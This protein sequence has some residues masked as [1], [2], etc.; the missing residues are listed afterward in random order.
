M[1]DKTNAQ[2]RVEIYKKIANPDYLIEGSVIDRHKSYIKRKL[3]NVLKGC[4][5][6]LSYIDERLNKEDDEFYTDTIDYMMNHMAGIMKF[7][8]D[9]GMDD[10]YVFTKETDRQEF[11]NNLHK[12]AKTAASVFKNKT[13]TDMSAA[14]SM[15]IVDQIF[16]II[17][18][19]RVQK[20]SMRFMVKGENIASNI[21]SFYKRVHKKDF[22]HLFDDDLKDFLLEI[23]SC[24]HNGHVQGFVPFR[25]QVCKNTFKFESED[26][27]LLP[28]IS[29]NFTGMD[30]QG[31]VYGMG[32]FYLV[33]GKED[34]FADVRKSV[35]CGTCNDG[36]F[37]S[38]KLSQ[39]FS[40]TQLKGDSIA[41]CKIPKD[42]HCTFHAISPYK[43]LYLCIYA[44]DCYYHRN[45]LIRSNSRL[46]REY[47]KTPVYMITEEKEKRGKTEVT[48]T[49]TIS[50]SDRYLY[51]RENN[52]WKG[53]H[54]AS[55][56][57]HER[58]GFERRIFDKETGKV[59][60]VVPVKATHVK[61]VDKEVIYKV[62]L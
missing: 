59:K 4:G 38:M 31:E 33:K 55:P 32:E 23:Q 8:G 10:E 35:I 48:T 7:I 26:G 40:G 25:V 43:L 34:L 41:L 27:T 42:T 6:S 37:C 56:V 15:K 49:R 11:L 20:Q 58:R 52:L 54:H 45:T 21:H 3:K 30:E 44:W 19:Y 5:M 16:Q 9:G 53:G 62:K 51:E 46:G 14:F 12:T 39:S 47:D 60:K 22:D 18:A 28:T 24:D 13:I 57:S 29:V 17:D 1:L 50:L 2:Q 36:N 61:G